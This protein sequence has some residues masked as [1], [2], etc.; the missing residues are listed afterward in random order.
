MQ[1]PAPSGAVRETCARLV[2]YL[3]ATLD[4]HDS[5]VIEPRTPLVH[6]WGSPPIVLRCG[7]GTPAGY[8]PDSALVTTVNGVRWFQ[9]NGDD[10]VTWTAVR[11]TANVELIVPHD[12]E[13]QG[14]FL[15]ELASSI[16]QT[17][18]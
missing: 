7:V 8:D 10:K 6:V 3:P 5:R 4:G 15:V 12:Y 2:N 11:R 14:G 18:E 16:K 1:P 9:H 17:I 13:S